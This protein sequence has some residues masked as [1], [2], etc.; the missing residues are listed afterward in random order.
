MFSRALP[1]LAVVLVL[2]IAP[3]AAADPVVRSAAGANA[4]AIQGTVDQFRN[5]LGT[6]NANQPGS[7]GSGRREI[8]W[9]G[10]SDAL[11]SPNNLPADFFNKTSPRGAVFG[12]LGSG[13]QVSARAASGTTVRFGNILA[14]YETIFQAFSPERL[15]AAIG[16]HVMDVRFFVPGSTTPAAVSGFGAVFTDVD[17][18]TQT[19]IE[20]FDPFGRSLG[21]FSV[22]A[23]DQGLSFLGVSFDAGERVGRVVIT[24]GNRGFGQ[25]DTGPSG[26]VVVM[27]DFIYG[28]PVA[29][30]GLQPGTLDPSFGSEGKLVVDLPTSTTD[31]FNAVAVQPDGRIVAAGFNDGGLPD[32]AVARFNPDGTLDTSFGGQG[33]D[34]P[35]GIRTFTFGAPP[36][37]GHEKA[38]DV[39]IQADGKIVVVGF[40]D[41]GTGV[42]DGTQ[43][44][45][46]IARLNTNGTLDTT[47]G[48]TATGL[49][50][51]NLPDSNRDQF[52]AV[53]IQPDGKIVAA[54]FNDGGLPDFAVARFNPDGSLDTTFNPA[55]SAGVNNFPGIRTFTFGAP[56]FGGHEKA[57]DVALQEDGRIVV[58]GFT[59]AG[60]GVTNGTQTRAAIA[61]LNTN[62][63]LDTTFGSTATGLVTV[64][65]P[66]SNRD[67]FNAVV[68]QPDGKIVAAGFNDGGLPDAAVA[69][70]NPDG[71]LDTSF[72]GQGINNFPGVR[73][74]TFGTPPFGGH[75][76]LEDVA[77]LRDG[78]ILVV[79]FTDA[80]T[81]VTN[82]S[83]FLTALAL[84]NPDGTLDASFGIDGRLTTR[85]DDSDG[86]A[87]G[88]AVQ[89]NG[90]IVVSGF[91]D[92]EEEGQ[93][94]TVVRLSIEA[95][96]YFLAEGASGPFFDVRFA[97]ANPD[98]TLAASG[99]LFFL[100]DQGVTT[101]VPVSVPP[102]ARLT[103]DPKDP[104]IFGNNATAFSTVLR[105]DL[106][107]VF[108][109]LMSWDGQGY[110]AHLEKSI[111]EPQ[112]VWYLAEGATGPFDLFYLL[113]NPDPEQTATVKV[114]YL[115]L[116][117]PPLE[118]TVLV[119]PATRRNIYV[120]LEGA[121]GALA[122]DEFS[123]KLESDIP[124]I[125]E[126]AMY[127]NAA[128]VVAGA[129][130]GSAG[131]PELSTTWFLAEGATGPWF[132]L[133]YLLGNPNSIS[134]T[135]QIEYLLNDGTVLTKSYAV[136]ANSR[137]TIHVDAE[138]F[139]D[140]AGP[141][142]LADAAVAARIT[143]TVPIMVERAMW[144]PGSQFA[145]TWYEAHAS[146]AVTGSGI[147]WGIA[148][149]E[150]GGA[151]GAE[152]YILVANVSNAPADVKVT[153]LFDD[154]TPPVERT[155]T[156]IDPNS[157]FNVAVQMEFPGVS[158]K[159]FSAIVESLGDPP[160][161]LVVE[162]AIY[163]SALGQAWM[164]GSNALATKLQ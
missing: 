57:F 115:R 41:A 86:Q 131:I 81:G 66:D 30:P 96:S 39:A 155:F 91:T 74:F 142:L 147:K 108:A 18:A 37:G 9:D 138:R 32:F 97:I 15:F 3:H 36:F 71:T 28:E 43:T 14:Q 151:R 11:S 154:G 62:G 1:H 53:V 139:P 63:T 141:Q 89:P 35:P 160:A 47:F 103:V 85:F 106:P 94:A 82:G 34:D 4:A 144:W 145:A 88:V 25:S 101:Q 127:L 118:Q 124:I 72:G 120:N 48:S 17:S 134:G 49:V 58:V 132:D 60:T 77:L 27:D 83:R 8:N 75:E 13:F 133:F 146:A 5:D 116:I 136:P 26:D 73:T 99:M 117:G 12:T 40:T 152:T 100:D 33:I 150:V 92:V 10:V 137:R 157:R 46:A 158:N 102:M 93:Q 149:G 54:G 105:S 104:A 121:G 67:Q 24:L 126:R 140:P 44:R 2:T 113:Q 148:E 52:N 65:L 110:G 114:T 20:Y 38:F 64:N 162:Q 76:K 143:S 23:H 107:L 123:A 109:R 79:G 59:D 84:L 45:A 95:F 122:N 51:V 6:L 55:P 61:R 98:P 56:P 111:D 164:A 159:R 112:T 21:R 153:L 135:A 70:F 7:L 125:V 50:T 119:P 156:G 42:T 90:Q 129:G 87:L 31:H 22:P 163:W 69:R 161:Q 29:T 19:T 80:G 78:R 16:H 68:I 130:H 128:G